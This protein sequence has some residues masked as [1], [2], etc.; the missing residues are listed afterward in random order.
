MIGRRAGWG[1]ATANPHPWS[2]ISAHERRGEGRLLVD[3]PTPITALDSRVLRGLIAEYMRF[4]FVD[5]E[6]VH[7]QCGRILDSLGERS[8]GAVR[9]RC[10]K[11]D[12]ALALIGGHQPFKTVT[13]SA[14]A[15]ALDLPPWHLSRLVKRETGLTFRQHLSRSPCEQIVF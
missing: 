7:A 11:V 14:V 5:D 10:Y 1:T 9:V 12:L 6:V 2:A 3:L 8:D 4:S 15:R 13:L